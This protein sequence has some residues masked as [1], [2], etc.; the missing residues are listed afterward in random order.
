MDKQTKP[1]IFD[2]ILL[3]LDGDKLKNDIFD[4]LKMDF[5]PRTGD[6][7]EVDGYYFLVQSVMYSYKS[8]V[9]VTAYVDCLGDAD[10]YERWIKKQLTD[11]NPR[12][13]FG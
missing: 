2:V 9:C 11:S 13:H 3:Q 1:S 5:V 4:S 10:E 7:I 6:V 8:S 12:I